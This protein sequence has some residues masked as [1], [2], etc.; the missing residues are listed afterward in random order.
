MIEV[1]D[2]WEK[3]FMQN[4]GTRHQT[5]LST[6]AICLL[7]FT[8][9]IAAGFILDGDCMASPED[10]SANPV[11]SVT[12]KQKPEDISGIEITIDA[13]TLSNEELKTNRDLAGTYKKS[14][15]AE[16]NGY[17]VQLSAYGNI[18][19]LPQTTVADLEKAR[20][21]TLNTLGAIDGK[22]KEI[23]DK[24]GLFNQMLNQT[25][26]QLSLNEKQLTDISAVSK[27]D[28]V[29]ATLKKNLQTLIALLTVKQKRIEKILD[30]YQPLEL[31]LEETRTAISDL[32]EKLN[33]QIALKKKEAL[34]QRS[35]SPFFALN[36]VQVQ[37][38]ISAIFNKTWKLLAADFWTLFTRSFWESVGQR[39]LPALI[40]YAGILWVM[41]RV[42][43]FCRSYEQSGK[44]VKTPWRHLSFCMLEKSLIL[45]GTTAFIAGYM[46]LQA[47]SA[48][49]AKWG[50]AL[51]LLWF[52]LLT[53]WGLVGIQTWN[54]LP[55][56]AIPSKISHGLCFGLRSIRLLW[57]LYLG[58]E[59][60]VDGT[61]SILFLARILFGIGLLTGYILFWKSVESCIPAFSGGFPLI[62]P[63][64][65]GV[66]YAIAGLGPVLELIGYGYLAIYWFTSWIIT[67]VACFW[68]GILMM[69]LLEWQR[70]LRKR[71][72]SDADKQASDR[73]TLQWLS[74][75]LLWAIWFPIFFIAIMM[76]W[77]AKNAVIIG[78]FRVINYPIPIGDTQF[79]I[80]GFVCSALMLLLTELSTRLW[81]KILREKFLAGS[82]MDTGLKDSI[83]TITTYLIWGIGIFI[84]LRM[85]GVSSTSLT[86]VFGALSIGLG[87]GLQNIFN[88]FISGIILLFER[89]I[90]VGDAVEING[91][92]GVVQKIN[93]RS[94]LVQTYDNASLI[95]PNSEFISN[96]VINWSFKD[97]RIRRVITVGVAYGSDT[98]LVSS[99]LT[100]IAEKAQWVL[101]TPESDVLFSDFGDSALIFKLRVWTLVDQ[102]VKVETHIRFEIE[103]LFRERHIEIPFPQH[104][105]HIIRESVAKI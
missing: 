37:S 29:T 8:A 49:I 95:I 102:M 41:L 13:E 92:W 2:H 65:A 78:F 5:F 11:P 36:V 32:S 19:L 15:V 7:A 105:V 62:R 26:E 82:G 17:S 12:E 55:L 4:F 80:M 14:F 10:R 50:I 64:A 91:I 60:F 101:K 18:L 79:S 96:K 42:R 23:S 74:M 103:R 27:A 68:G 39:L 100:E 71:H 67:I 69:A 3:Q 31:Q 88:N 81:R 46:T 104:D 1:I 38:E 73:Y 24:T 52:W 33:G 54:R 30:I 85:I 9:M 58:L 43:R 61:G 40:L 66:G 97:H 25:L 28:P 87:F 99:T 57:I 35:A 72:L 98:A 76:A 16:L 94:T 34:F 56:P 83:T 70:E 89:P 21:D 63:I 48:E 6:F 45:A 90:Q 51:D 53:Q 47:E 86:V 75:R 59:W 77:G 84:S 44:L 22:L 20:I 93:V